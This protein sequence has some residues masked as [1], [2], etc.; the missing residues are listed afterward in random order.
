MALPR[1]EAL[2]GLG[3]EWD[4]HSTWEDRLIELADYRKNH[5]HCNVSK[6]DSGH[7]KLAVGS[8]PKEA[9]TGYTWKERRRL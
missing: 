7:I 4:S 8:Q 6:S 3:F 5:G 9:I 2:E 1:V